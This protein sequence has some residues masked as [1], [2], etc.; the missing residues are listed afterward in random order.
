M[1]GRQ[2]H[3]HCPFV[4]FKAP[5]FSHMH[6]QHYMRVWRGKGPKQPACC[7]MHACMCREGTEACSACY[8]P[9]GVE[10]LFYGDSITETWR[11]TDMGRQCSRCAGVPDVFAKHFGTKYAAEVLAVGG[12]PP[13]ACMH[14]PPL[15][16]I[17]LG[18]CWGT[19]KR[20]GA[21]GDNISPLLLAQGTRRR[22]CSGAWS[23]GS[24]TAGPSRA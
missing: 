18:R 13:P 3:L 12:T 20:A 14:A 11:G 2:E 1:P 15:H 21:E 24:C 19:C 23:M 22:T 16:A 17:A 10:L 7:L 6:I 9:Q 8:M 5:C 4:R